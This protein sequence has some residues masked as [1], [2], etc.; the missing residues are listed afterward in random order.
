MVQ[1]TLVCVRARVCVCARASV[2]TSRFM[3]DTQS[4]VRPLSSYCTANKAEKQDVNSSERKDAV[5]LFS[6]ALIKESDNVI[7]TASETRDQDRFRNAV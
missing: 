5:P 7:K 6:I 1:Q 2:L 4:A 3:P